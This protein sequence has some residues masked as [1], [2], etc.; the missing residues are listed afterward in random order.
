MHDA[1]WM[2]HNF[3]VVRGYIEQPVGLDDLQALIHQRGGVDGHQPAHV[4]RG[5][6]QGLLYRYVPQLFGRR[7]AKWSSRCRKE[8]PLDALL[9]RALNALEEGGMLAVYRQDSGSAA[10][11]Q[12][13]GSPAGCDQDL[14]A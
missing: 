4:P 8:K 3:Y 5:M 9:R 11:R 12:R 7:S 13:H 10:L 1:L 14:L 6:L 2:D